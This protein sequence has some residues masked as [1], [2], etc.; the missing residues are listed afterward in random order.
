MIVTFIVLTFLVAAA[1]PAAVFWSGVRAGL[2]RS[3]AR[4][5]T[6]LTLYLVASWLAA[7][8]G[9]AADGWLRF[10]RPPTMI[11]LFVSILAIAIAVVA[12][13]LGKRL[14]TQLPLWALVGFQVFRAGVELL[15]HRAYVEGV[16][17]RQMSYSGRNFDII[18]ALTAALVAVWLARGGRS[19]RVVL[20]WNVLGTLLL[21][22][23]LSVAL[24]SA[25]TRLRVTQAPW[26]WLPAVMVLAAIIGHGLVYR[27]LWL[28]RS[29]NSASYVLA[30]AI[31]GNVI[32]G[33]LFLYWMIGHANTLAVAFFI[34]LVMS[35]LFLSYLFARK[36]LGRVK[37]PW[38]IVATLLG[39][40]AFGTPLY[41][42][43]NWRLSPEPRPD[44]AE[45]WSNS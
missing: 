36:P 17:P 20:A 15:L 22:N 13:P 16:M 33:G 25:P 42:W 14:A 7:T 39:T 3:R 45:W 5:D 43:L 19:M 31:A 44:F 35:M 26:V 10:T 40:L 18:S 9:A 38:L 34:D 11:A 41:L 24:Q 8:G 12:S 1:F 4:R 37:W 27:R 23:T 2:D 30:F 29:S 6:A 32:P 21:A 28:E